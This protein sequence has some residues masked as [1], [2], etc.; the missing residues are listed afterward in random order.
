M[1]TAF[2]VLVSATISVG[3]ASA[4]DGTAFVERHGPQFLF[5]FTDEQRDA[6]FE[7]LDVLQ[8][9]PYMTAD[10]TSERA[11]HEQ[12]RRRISGKLLAGAPFYD[13]QWKPFRLTALDGTFWGIYQ[14]SL[15]ERAL[16]GIASTWYRCAPEDQDTEDMQAAINHCAE[17]MER[18]G[19]V[20]G[21]ISRTRHMTPGGAVQP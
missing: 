16:L 11:A 15:P 7:A 17:M 14:L 21:K 9:S 5:A 12:R 8:R 4:L 13:H 1:R 2:L 3:T 10:V 18:A 20:F 19:A 6:A